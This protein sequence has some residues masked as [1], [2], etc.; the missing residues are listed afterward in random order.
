MGKLKKKEE[1]TLRVLQKAQE[2]HKLYFNL[3]NLKRFENSMSLKLEE[4]GIFSSEFEF[5]YNTLIE[6]IQSLSSTK[7]QTEIALVIMKEGIKTKLFL[8]KKSYKKFLKELFKNVNEEAI[9]IY[10]E[11]I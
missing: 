7:R 6:D 11:L 8:N 10:Q 4:H 3:R 1:V 9:F 2:S 5:R